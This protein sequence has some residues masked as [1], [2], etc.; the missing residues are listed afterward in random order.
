MAKKRKIISLSPEEAKKLWNKSWDEYLQS[1]A[2][3]KYEEKRCPSA[4][5]MR[6][7]CVL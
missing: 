7:T 4:E 5:F 2:K 3:N 1:V 6:K